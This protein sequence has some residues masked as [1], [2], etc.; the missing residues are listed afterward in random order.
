[1]WKAFFREMEKRAII[2]PALIGGLT[3]MDI[4]RQTRQMQQKTKLTSMGQN[5]NYELGSPYQYQFEGGKH[6][7][8]KT[9]RSPH[10]PLY[11]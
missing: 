1:M 4:G 9:L 2:G 7:N 6:T 10:Q 11:S 8:F 3:A 5:R